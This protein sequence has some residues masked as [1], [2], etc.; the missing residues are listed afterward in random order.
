MNL[1]RV[2]AVTLLLSLPLASAAQVFRCTGSAGKVEYTDAPCVGS[3]GRPVN[4]QHNVLPAQELRDQSLKVENQ[5][6]RAELAAAKAQ[7]GP[8]TQAAG[9]SEADLQAEKG[10][11]IECTRAKRGYEVATSSIQTDRNTDAEALAVYSACGL[12]PPDKTVVQVTTVVVARPRAGSRIVG[13]DRLGCVDERGAR[14]RTN[15]NGLTMG[16]GGACTLDGLRLR[17]P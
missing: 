10:G 12:K 5:R 7:G 17:C 1:K 8:A 11:T 4:V 6:L 9:R 14:Y 3:V 15:P 2:A 16:P 13:C